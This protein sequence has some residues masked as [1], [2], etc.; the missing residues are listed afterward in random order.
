[1]FSGRLVLMDKGRDK[2]EIEHRWSFKQQIC[3]PLFLFHALI[4]RTLEIAVQ[5]WLQ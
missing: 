3:R 5:A 4:Q 1:M 2:I